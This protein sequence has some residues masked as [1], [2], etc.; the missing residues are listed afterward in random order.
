MDSLLCPFYEDLEHSL[1][2][3]VRVKIMWGKIFLWWN[4][5]TSVE[6]NIHALLSLVSDKSDHKKKMF[7]LFQLKCF[8]AVIF[9]A[10]WVIW[11]ARNRK[12]FSDIDYT[13]EWCFFEVKRHSFSW[14]LSRRKVNLNWDE[15]VANPFISCIFYHALC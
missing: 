3:C 13:I 9:T 7:H 8:K 12:I 5:Q 15:W 14:I 6:I 4:F 2:A 10:A 1:I 11:N